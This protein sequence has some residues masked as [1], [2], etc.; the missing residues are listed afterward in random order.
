MVGRRRARGVCLCLAAALV[1]AATAGGDVVR[2]WQFN[3]PGDTEGW[4]ARSTWT[5]PGGVHV[6]TD[7][8]GAET[9]L[10]AA[11]IDGNGDAGIV[12][13]DAALPIELPDDCI[14]WDSLSIRLRHLNGNP[15]DG[16]PM[17][18]AGGTGL[19]ITGA[20]GV[21][22]GLPAAS[23]GR[24]HVEPQNDHWAV[25]TI[26]LTG[27]SDDITSFRFDPSSDTE[28]NFEIDWME[29]TAVSGTTPPPP[30]ERSVYYIDAVNGSDYTGDGSEAHPYQTIGHIWNNLTAADEVILADGE[31]GVIEIHCTDWQAEPR[32]VFTDWVTVRAADGATPTLEHVWTGKAVGSAFD[33]YL[34][35]EGIHITDGVHIQASRY[36]AFED[37]RITR[38]GPYTGSEENIEKQAVCFN[39]V[40]YGTIAGCEITETGVGIYASGRYIDILDNHIHHGSHDGI[41]PWDLN[42]SLIEGNRIHDFDDGVS[43]DEASWS[44]HCDLI[45]FSIRGP[46]YE[47]WGCEN[48]T[49]RGNTL[50][51]CESQALIVNG[52]LRT[53]TR[54]SNI[55]VE[56]NIFGPSKANMANIVEKLD[57]FIFRNN[58]VCYVGEDYTYNRWP[59]DDYTLRIGGSLTGVQV[60]NNILVDVGLS[61]DAGVE[62]FDYN[63]IMEPVTWL[64]GVDD[65]RGYGRFTIFGGDGDLVDPAAFDGILAA[66]SPM[67]NAGTALAATAPQTDYYGTPRDARPDLG[68]YEM[69]GLSPAAETGPPVF[70]DEVTIFVDDFEDGHYADVDP[71]LRAPTTQGMSWYR[72]AGFDAYK[73]YVAWGTLN[74]NALHMPRGDEVNGR[75]AWLL[76]EQ[77][78]DWVDYTFAFT[79]NNA[80]LGFGGGVVVLVRDMDNC[81]YLDIARGRLVRRLDGAET[82]LTTVDAIQMPATGSRR[83]AVSVD[84]EPAGVTI[85]VDADDDGTTDLTFTDAD[86]TALATLNA[87]GVGFHCNNSDKWHVLRFDDLRVEVAETRSGASGDCDGDGDVDL[88]DFAI[89]KLNFGRSGVTAGAAEGDLDGD[90]DVDLDDFAIL[91]TTFG[92]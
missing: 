89:V 43:D 82:V 14:E 64:L 25:Y 35:F 28:G 84:V 23:E 65:S 69:P 92:T 61:E 41:R 16:Q 80:Y 22:G 58:T 67:I 91:K 68:A 54:H 4:Q 19:W 48:V 76:G 12:V 75:A 36:V 51:H 8:D 88:D 73:Y 81:Y 44:K 63:L 31:Y 57:G 7:V 15:P 49:V 32:P 1:T 11:D 53:D 33:L 71:W 46:G 10:T 39:G 17:P 24:W 2:S 47:G 40:T 26:D 20:G 9:V 45:H 79:A 59:Q 13:A 55:I 78:G 42:D 60:Y 5:L 50:Y 3:T 18:Y 34:R 70:N 52:Y 90:G 62:V 21:L 56:N 29:L 66:T 85:A 86:P 72:P 37:C 38:V 30:P 6:A 74:R 27:A 87:G 83:Y 77:G